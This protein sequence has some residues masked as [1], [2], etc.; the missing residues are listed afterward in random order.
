MKHVRVIS[1]A[2]SIDKKLAKLDDHINSKYNDM[3]SKYDAIN[4]KLNLL[5]EGLEELKPKRR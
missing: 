3:S 4:A 1:Q 5:I 2:E